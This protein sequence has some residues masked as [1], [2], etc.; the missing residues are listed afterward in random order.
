MPEHK[1]T[2]RLIDSSSPYLLQHAH[3]PVDWYPWCDEALQRAKDEDRPIFLSIGYS[4]CHWCHVMER[5]SFEN[6][7]IARVM[8]EHFVCI[9]VDR[10]ERPDLDAIYMH[11]VQFMTGSGGWPMS[12]FLT[13][14]LKP[15]FGGTYFPPDDRYGRPGF[16]RVLLS[17]ARIFR[18][19]RNEIEDSAGKLQEAVAKLAEHS[20]GPGGTLD[21]TPIQEVVRRLY[22]EFDGTWGGFGAAPKFPQS[23]AISL[24]L[25]HH[26]RSG[27]E[28]ALRM[29]TTTLDRMALG[30]LYDQLGGGFHR[31]SVD[32][33][34]LVPHF[35]KMLYDNAQLAAV[36]LE[37]FQLTGKPLYR[38]VAVE[39]LDFV[40][41][42]MT[43]EAGGF[44][45]TLDAD[46]E[47]EEGK[48]YLWDR[49]EIVQALGSDDAALFCQYFGVTD[50][51]NFE[52]HSIL[53]IAVPLEEFAKE[54]GSSADDIQAQLDRMRAK[55]LS[56]R[57]ARVP[58]GK[59]DKVLTDW[60]GL[61][62][63]ALARVYQVLGAE[64]YRA[65]AERAAAFVLTDMRRDGRLL[66]AYRKGRSHIGA[67]LDDH[68]FMIQAL[69][70]L[71]EATFD[72]RWIREA[73]ALAAAMIDGFWD[74]AG[75]GFYFTPTGQADIIVRT[76][77]AYD[78]A[79]PSGNSV[80]AHALLRLAVLTDN[81]EYRDKAEK[82]LLAFRGEVV[83]MPSGH[84]RLLAALDFHL[85]PVKEIVVCGPAAHADTQDLLQAVRRRYLPNRILASFD[86]RNG[87]AAEAAQ[88]V[89]LLES[90]RMGNAKPAAFV[91][92]R[93]TCSAPA[94]TPEALDALLEQR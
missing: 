31:Y 93:Q 14:D 46:S 42:E 80:A 26:D 56:I 8:N 88:V 36:Y 11:A 47:G 79:T 9:K 90:H 16:K 61:M 50:G 74:E 92:E 48:Y 57:A 25:R 23:A 19:K 73:E 68:A 76:K 28:D 40:L 70:D 63:S 22:A 10:E 27:G 86:P 13:P 5:E 44:H 49:K 20:A 82:T 54:H 32:R 83:R 55:L 45:S 78:G 17:A 67:Y 35:E 29:A 24:L 91:C 65:A 34:W 53:N 59:D 39:T 89:K 72:V 2:N 6:E 77:S 66:H 43:D 84:V 51:G 1:H 94:T 58:P 52:G 64:R 60:N 37:A 75:G 30:G 41:R 38:R 62:I 85:G 12:V 21:R 3:N 4:A 18:E 69:V 71:Y 87:S 7:E 15:F 33:E 81:A